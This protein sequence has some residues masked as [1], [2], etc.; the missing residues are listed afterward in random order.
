MPNGP[1]FSAHS[2]EGGRGPHSLHPR[3]YAPPN[4]HAQSERAADALERTATVHFSEPPPRGAEADPAG[5]SLAELS[6][7]PAY[8]ERS[9]E[10]VPLP[11][12]GSGD[13]VEQTSM[14]QAVALKEQMVA[15]R[16][17]VFTLGAQ[18][19]R[20]VKSH[21]QQFGNLRALR[22]QVYREGIASRRSGDGRRLQQL[23]ALLRKEESLFANTCV[24]YV[25]FRCPWLCVRCRR[26]QTPPPRPFLGTISAV[27][28]TRSS[29][30]TTWTC[31]DV[32]VPPR[33]GPA[34][35]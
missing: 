8:P 3:S 34:S 28:S 24:M 5:L 35:R 30:A 7:Q 15:L 18:L 20:E 17:Q 13:P 25:C 31:W 12:R 14:K 9:T 29:I 11:V 22:E 21:Q 16:E 23:E 1:R 26:P 6:S 33:P 19:E 32:C 27:S 10:S 2:R 4:P